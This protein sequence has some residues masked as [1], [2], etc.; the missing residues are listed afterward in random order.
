M[1][2]A[3]TSELIGPPSDGDFGELVEHF[4]EAWGQGVPPSL[5]EFLPAATAP[6]ARIPWSI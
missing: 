5:E 6:D 1:P 2:K 4:E 3:P